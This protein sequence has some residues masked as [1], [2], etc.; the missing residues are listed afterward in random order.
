MFARSIA[1]LA[2]TVLLA[3]ASLAQAKPVLSPPETAT[4]AL[5]GKTIAIKYGA[6]SMRGRKIMGEVVP[7]NEVWRTGAN[8]ATTF[9][10]KANL[11]IGS[12]TVP[13]GSYTLYTLPSKTEWLLIINKQT[14]QWGT[15]YH[16]DR[17]LVRI[18]MKGTTLASPQEK[19]SISFEKTRGNATEL[20]VR[21]ENTDESVS[22]TAQ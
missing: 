8:P 3:T 4:V 22:I 20:H 10:T 21:W 17:D 13:A 14:G 1:S 7:Y 19:M 6:P 5:D 9:V 15:E 11:K 12:A 18:P 2:C 16:Q